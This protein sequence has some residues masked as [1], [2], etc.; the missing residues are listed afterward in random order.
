M[1]LEA[2]HNLLLDQP[3]IVLFALIATGLLLGGGAL[4]GTLQE[5][6]IMLFG[7][8]VCISVL[9]LIVAWPIATKYFKM[10]P[11]QALGGICGGM[12]STPALGAITAKTD[13]Q[14]PVTS[15]VSAY[16]IALIFMIIISKLLIRLL[17]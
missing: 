13:S 2:L 3:L 4:V 17:G 15:Y 7:L 16:P 1:S 10:N 6:G 8:G 9:P 5:H 11:L 12:T 14:I